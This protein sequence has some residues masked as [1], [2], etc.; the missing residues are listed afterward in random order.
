MNRTVRIRRF[1]TPDVLELYEE[2]VPVLQPGMALVRHTAI[3]L[4]YLDIYQREGHYP[5]PLPTGLGV[6]GAG[7]VEAVGDDVDT[8]VAGD[9][10]AHAGPSPGSYAS[11]PLAP[12]ERPVLRP[13]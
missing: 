8:V 3:G 5:L 7:V 2:D 6:A 4:N 11:S 10:V 9:R 13:D 1:G 12:A